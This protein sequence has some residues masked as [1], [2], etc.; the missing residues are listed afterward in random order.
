MPQL[1]TIIV[2]TIYLFI[3]LILIAF[4][5]LTFKVN[6]QGH[7]KE[8]KPYPIKLP[9]HDPPMAM[10]PHPRAE[11]TFED[12]SLPPGERAAFPS[13]TSPATIELSVI[14]PAYNEG[15]RLPAMLDETI[16][17]LQARSSRE[18]RFTWEIIIVDDGSADRTA[19]VGMRYV[20]AE[21]AEKVRVLRML[22]N[23]GKG[24]AVRH[25]VL[26][27][28]GRF[29]LMADADGATRFED[30]EG[31]E[32]VVASGADVAVGSRVHLRK[33]RK[34]E[35]RALVRGFVSWVFNLLVVYL[36]GVVGIADTQCGFKLYSRRAARVAFV[37]QRLQRWAFDVENLYRV[38][39]AGLEVVEVDVRWTEVAGSKV[40]M[41]NAIL[42]MGVDMLRMRVGYGSGRWNLAE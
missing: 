6:I 18:S 29:V 32:A 10:P 8:P 24:A 12:P 19:D 17:Y 28:R 5:P 11:Q 31:L 41:V 27:A 25:G 9:H 39:R 42:N 22:E 1:E 23:G 3:Q 13:L 14:V 38:Q 35:R 21:G 7:P 15:E 2:I 30:L 36:G 16:G 33:G 4:T 26:V 20:V 40:S 37:G 34:E